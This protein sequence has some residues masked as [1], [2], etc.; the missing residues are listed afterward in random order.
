MDVIINFFFLFV[1]NK[2]DTETIS[3]SKVTFEKGH[4]NYCRQTVTVDTFSE[5]RNYMSIN[6]ILFS[7][8]RKN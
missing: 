8:N 3:P 2:K 5:G 7:Y 6:A 1:G 4:P